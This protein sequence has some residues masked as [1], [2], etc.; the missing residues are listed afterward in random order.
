MKIEFIDIQNYRKLKST[1]IYLGNDETIFVGANNSGKTS[2]IDALIGFL[3]QRV[4]S[5]ESSEIGSQRRFATTDFTLCN[6][7]TLN[8]Y[9]K[10]WSDPDNVS[11]NSLHEWQPFC[12]SLDIW[13]KVDVDEI[14][15]VSHLVPTLKWRGGLLGVRLIYQPKSIE[16]LMHD[17]LQ[18][19][20]AALLVTEELKPKEGVKKLELWPR[21]MREYLDKKMNS[22]FDV[23][24]YLLDPT[25]AEENLIPQKLSEDQIPLNA[26][27]FHGLFNVNVIEAQRGFSDPHA[28]NNLKG[29]SSLS[30]QLNQYYS[31]HLNPSDY[32]EKEDIEALEAIDNAKTIF[33]SKLNE[34]FNDA[35]GELKG[36]GYPGFNDPDIFLSSNT[37]PVEHLAHN[38]TVIFDIQKSDKDQ[39]RELALPES[40]YGLGYKNLI[41]MIFKL[42]GFRD[43]WMRK[44]KAEKRRTEDDIAKEPLHLVLIEEPEAHLH[45]QVQQVFIRKAFEV[46]QKGVLAPFNTQLVVSSHSSYIAH[47]VGFEKLRY[48]KRHPSTELNRSPRAEVIGF[49]NVFGNP[50]KRDNDSELTAKFVTRY[51]KT[52]H[53]DLFFANG[54][55]LVEGAAERMLLPHFIRHK[56]DGQFGLNRSYISILE[57]GG[58][59]AQRLKPLIDALGLPTLV[60]TDTDAT[61]P[62]SNNSSTQPQR[63]KGQR[64]GSS[65]LKQWFNLNT[66][67]LDEIL[68][69]GSES[70]VLGNAR[71]A[72]QYDIE[73]KYNHKQEGKAIPY[74]FE[75]S[76]ALTNIELLKKLTKPTGM[77]KKMKD[78]CEMDTLEKCAE[79]MYKALDNK[80]KAQMALDIIY[81]IDPSE[82]LIPQ[83]VLEGLEWLQNELHKASRDFV[84][85]QLVIEETLSGQ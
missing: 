27:P 10:S 4:K 81:D 30:S 56:F 68:D 26:Y 45:A 11:G 19:Y 47:E 74:T 6:W 52:T 37:G 9:A 31:R 84:T 66:E 58:A 71:A 67:S 33:D 29:P 51:L 20:N 85:E 77:M 41:Y 57:V 21:D 40:Y 18:E 17:F 83:Y 63:G 22:Y 13:L 16:S 62:E 80:G 2:A 61:D 59:H 42:I 12:P 64:S 70:K 73:V 72:Y 76:L 35:L 78:A 36:L 54:V 53:C 39:I 3:D 8:G 15:R 65:T 49:S 24:A 44:G 43:N 23:K 34:A 82:L 50:R 25:V 55:I 46:L 32:P 38:A 69:L 14:H 7:S 75:D 1:R 5:K 48:F 28:S 60:I 79:A